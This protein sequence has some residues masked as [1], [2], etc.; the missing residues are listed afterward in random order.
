MLSFVTIFYS[1]EIL[2]IKN[3][4]SIY[5]FKH[6]KKKG[7]SMTTNVPDTGFVGVHRNEKPSYEVTTKREQKEKIP[8]IWQADYVYSTK[9]SH[10]A[11][12]GNYL[13]G[14]QSV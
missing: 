1:C 4:L 10:G 14:S 6:E 12:I 7:L 2:Q 3:T 5:K 11:V 13:N 9:G 8:P